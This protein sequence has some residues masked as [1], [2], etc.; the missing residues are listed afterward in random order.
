[1]VAAVFSLFLFVLLAI[2]AMSGDRVASEVVVLRPPSSPV[3]SQNNWTI[4]DLD[5]YLDRFGTNYTPQC[6]AG[7][8]G[9]PCGCPNPTIGSMPQDSE[10][11]WNESWQF[12]NAK[13]Q[14]RINE[15][16]NQ[17]RQLDVILLGDS[18]TEHWQGT[19]LGNRNTE[20]DGNAQVYRDM[21]TSEDSPV[22]GL[23]LGNG[24]DRTT[25]LLYRVEQG[26]ID[27]LEAPVIWILIGTND[28]LGFSCSSDAVVAGILAIM[29]QVRAHK[30]ASTLV[31]QALLPARGNDAGAIGSWDLYSQINQRLECFAEQAPGVRFVNMTQAFLTVN[32]TV[33]GDLLIDGLHPGEE[34]SRV[35]G[36]R[37]VDVVQ[38]ILYGARIRRKSR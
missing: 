30:P 28:I 16:I 31:L 35:M 1:L 14:E 2:L 13:N 27:M 23:A 3:C 18:I 33:D 4:P 25:Q 26:E 21:F 5:E 17:G 9:R 6:Y 8:N 29:R 11:W 12:S 32:D 24:G 10:G 7:R 19:D 37:I 20:F 22:Q 38:D 15:T 34:G 36:Q